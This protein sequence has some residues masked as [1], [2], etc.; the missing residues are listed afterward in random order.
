M[1]VELL[2]DKLDMMLQCL[3]LQIYDSRLCNVRLE[4]LLQLIEGVLKPMLYIVLDC[5]VLLEIQID[6]LLILKIQMI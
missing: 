3:F 1:F 6:C 4:E 2:L 5:L